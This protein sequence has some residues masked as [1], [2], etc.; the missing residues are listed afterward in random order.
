MACFNANTVEYRALR[1]EFKDD[2]AIDVIIKNYQKI[3]K[4]EEIPSVSEAVEIVKNKKTYYSLQKKTFKKAVIGNLVKRKLI[5]RLGDTYYTNNTIPGD[6]KGTV[7]RARYNGEMAVKYLRD[8][9]FDEGLITFERTK[10]TFK[11]NVNEDIFTK[12][13]FLKER[14]SKDNTRILELVEHLSSLMPELK[15]SLMTPQQAREYLSNLPEDQRRNVNFK[16]VK[17]F[18]DPVSGNAVLIQGRVT[19][20]TAVEEVLHP[21]INSLF[22]D[23]RELFMNLHKEAKKTF[24]Q[25][26]AQIENAYKKGFDEQTRA[27][28]LVT[29]SLARHFNKEYET[30]PARSWFESIIEFL[31]WFKDIVKNYYRDYVGKG[32]PLKTEYINSSATLSDI[33]K[34][35]NT[36]DL[37]FE[38]KRFSNPQTVQYSLTPETQDTLD[39]IKAQ[40]NGVQRE[41]IDVLFHDI[42][43]GSVASEDL[44]AS[45]VI[46]NKEDHTYI[47]IDTGEIYRSATE[48]IKGKL[49][50]PEGAFELNRLLGND[51]DTILNAVCAGLSFDRIPA[52]ERLSEDVA[53]Q[54]YRDLSNRINAMRDDRSVFIP[55]VV[56]AN[57]DTMYAGTLDI[58]KIDPQGVITIIDLK[59]SKYSMMSEGYRKFA[60]PVNKGSH[61]YAEGEEE[62]FKMTTK[63]QHG[64]QVNFYRRLLENL[65]YTVSDKSMT[66]HL[67]L[68]IEGKGKEQIFKNEFKIEGVTYHPSSENMSYVNQ[69]LPLKYDPSNKSM[70]EEILG[71]ELNPEAKEDFL[72]DE[73]AKPE[74]NPKTSYDLYDSL[75]KALRNYREGLVT[76]EEV[77]QNTR[78]YISMDKGVQEIIDE[79]SVTRAMIDTAYDDPEEI[80]KVYIDIIRQ[81][82][83][84]IEEFKEYASDPFNYDKPEYINKILGWQKFVE[85]YRGLVNL[86]ETDG[87]NSTENSYKNKLQILLNELVGVRSPDGTILEKGMFDLAIRNYVRTLIKN[88]S[89]RTFESEALREEWLDEIMTTAKDLNVLEYST[90]DMATSRDALSAI[91]DKIFKRNQQIV[92]DRIDQRLPKIQKAA[93]KLAKLSKG[94]IDYSFL[95]QHVDGEWNGRYVKEIGPQYFKELYLRRD[96]LYNEKGDFKK[97]IQ[98][99]NIDDATPAQITYNKKLH[100]DRKAY[101]QFM[102]AERIGAAGPRDGRFHKYNAKFKAERNKHEVWLESGDDGYWVRRASVS[103]E[104]WNAYELKYYDSFEYD[105]ALYEDGNFTGQTIR[106]VMFAPK[107]SLTEVRKK[108]SN[109]ESMQDPKWLKLHDPKTELEKAQLEYYNMFIDVYENDLLKKLPENV[110]MIGKV[111]IIEQDTISTLKDKSNLVGKMWTGMGKW[112]RNLFQPQTTV[113]KVFTDENGHIIT[114]SLPIFFTGSVRTEEELKTLQAEIDVKEEEYKE[115]TTAAE[116]EAINSEIKILRGKF[117]ALEMKPEVTTLNRDMTKALIMFSAMAENYETMAASEDTYTAMIKVMEDREYTNSQGEIKVSGDE[118]IGIKGK[119]TARGE[120]RILMR[121]RKWMRM[122][123][124]NNDQ[125]TKTFWDK[126]AKGLIAQTSL[127]Y[128]GFNVFGNMNNY[129]YGKISNSVETLGGRFYDGKEMVKTVAEF[130]LR[131]IPDV[132]ANI[133]SRTD[134][135]R[136]IKEPLYGSKYLAAVNTFR[137]MDKKADMREQGRAGKMG[138]GLWRMMS[139]WGFLLQDSGEF[140]VQT[141]VG[142]AILRSTT[143]KDSN[144]GETMNLYEA[145]NFDHTTHELTLPE[146]WN[147][148]IFYNAKIDPQT[149]EKEEVDWND[150][151]R[152]ELRNYIREVNKHIHGNYAYEDRMVIQS[153]VIGQMA[154]QFHKWVAPAIKARFRPEYF[155]EN[156]GWLEGRYITFWKFMA[157]ASKNLGEISKLSSNFKEFHGEQGQNKLRNINRVMGEI[158]I[159]FT[160]MIIKMLMTFMFDDDKDDSDVQRRLENVFIY[161]ADRLQK[162]MVT[163]MPIPGLGGF[164]QLYQI[165][166]SPIAASRTLGEMGEALEMTIGSGLGWAF[167]DD[168]SFAD[169]RYVYKRGKRKG[170]MKLAKEWGDAI[171]AWYTLNRWRS[172][173]KARSFYVK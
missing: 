151:A 44:A 84:Q 31:K 85:S 29:Q 159:M 6:R 104:A 65:G 173:D 37:S 57:D 157:Y 169:S 165:F 91:M 127:A 52:M 95:E 135:N 121:A 136:K 12:Q 143:V 24:P 128:V 93:L 113:K 67:R 155:D 7:G 131:A 148:V 16:N 55:Q 141:K 61:F 41:I 2:V 142:V 30:K 14:N 90:G 122:T 60:Y 124:Y 8:Q 82:I 40:A 156:L 71:V 133:A 172:Y 115:A 45:R 25:L 92:Q 26:A 112:A 140:N 70:V 99:D 78:N 134:K 79:I 86:T 83:K 163:F 150:D 1:V 107:R 161:Q 68:D 66:L 33:A 13:D 54:A 15:V 22:I 111:P 117:R 42:Q 48:V 114:D 139:D 38:L 103:D 144:T 100:A 4:T 94:E 17:S 43:K 5:S 147:K 102:R 118:E 153:T 132:L 126:A 98:I 108:T 76:R 152:Y 170:K 101:S 164:Q 106:S 77:L 11:V 9:G 137:M 73:E 130:N 19:E 125:D 32:L 58:L 154:A 168:E 69:I 49:V 171:P 123:F 96:K 166:K 80:R 149:N 72:T 116:Q 23:N 39:R 119:R 28:E 75:F 64:M 145:L 56:V 105:K 47:N 110:K 18:F 167:M 21:F 87:L 146:R 20:D 36:K 81:S 120:S 88:K 160:T 3:N 109:G 35:L 50:D 97:Y 51:F 63:M 10:N 162:E 129:L 74:N 89:N 46:L 53:R 27:L 59:T 138:K 62:Q 158:G 34:I